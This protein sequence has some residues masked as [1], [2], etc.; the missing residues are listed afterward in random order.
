M[1]SLPEIWQI[2]QDEGQ[3]A[4]DLEDQGGIRG[5]GDWGLRA[6]GGKGPAEGDGEGG[7]G[8]RGLVGCQQLQGWGHS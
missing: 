4:Q 1:T 7:L 5:A 8:G 3:C 6:G 2:S